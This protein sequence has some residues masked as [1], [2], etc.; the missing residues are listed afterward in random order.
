MKVDRGMCLHPA[1]QG[2][3]RMEIAHGPPWA[4]VK[5]D[6]ADKAA[7][8]TLRV[9]SEPEVPVNRALPEGRP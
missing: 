4:I 5:V 2:L 1:E 6:R 7:E 8:Q 3:V 9:P